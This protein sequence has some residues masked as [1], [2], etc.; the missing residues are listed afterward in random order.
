MLK[1]QLLT[2]LIPV[3]G[4]S[5]G[6]PDKNLREVGGM[7]LLERAIRFAKQSPRVDRVIV[8]TD[9]AR[10]QDMAQR[11]GAASPSLRPPH[12]ATDAATTADVAAHVL[13]EC[14]VNQGYLLVL[15]ATSPLR[16]LADLEALCALMEKSEAEACVSVVAVDEPRPEKMKR[17]VD[18]RIEPYLA[19]S[20]EGP[21]QALPQPY[22][23]NGAF[24]V[25][26][27]DAFRRDRKFIPKGTLAHV[28]PEDRSH[29][30]D[31][32]IDLRILEAMIAAG[33]WSFEALDRA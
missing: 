6:I 32:M 21:R 28:M 14:G 26:A 18:G 27:L 8:S 23:L 5:K 19:Q 9:D 20:F 16:Q 29:N 2:A 24:Y 12:L 11:F 33:H 30:L 10:M 15:Q 7:S 25:I 31:G 1:G 3:R 17:V 13:A 22:R 4:G